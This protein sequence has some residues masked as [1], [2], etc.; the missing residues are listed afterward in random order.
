MTEW[1]T[2]NQ[3]PKA[4]RLLALIVAIPLFAQSTA[5]FTKFTA[6]SWGI[7]VGASHCYAWNKLAAP[8]VT[9]IAC[10]ALAL[11]QVQA[12]VAG[13][14]LSGDFRSVDGDFTWIFS[15]SISGNGQVDYQI[16]ATPKG[17][18]SLQSTGTF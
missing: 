2:L 11:N 1:A 15:P 18:T 3:M 4:K 8:W 5:T 7:A 16:V 17:G 10:Y 13:Q 12:Q 14:I 6:T 9:E